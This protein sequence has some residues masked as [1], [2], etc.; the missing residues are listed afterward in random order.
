MNA[1]DRVEI[2]IAN[3]MIDSLKRMYGGD[4]PSRDYED[5]YLL[6]RMKAG[7]FERVKSGFILNGSPRCISCRTA[8]VI[9]FLKE[10]IKLIE[11]ENES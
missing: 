5:E 11:W 7:D 4:C 2:Q 8:E 3:T 1:Q 10:H 9:E 6:E